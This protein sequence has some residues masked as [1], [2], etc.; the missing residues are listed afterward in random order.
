MWIPFPLGRGIALEVMLQPGLAFSSGNGRFPVDFVVNPHNFHCIDSLVTMDWAQTCARNTYLSYLWRLYTPSENVHILGMADA[1]PA[2]GLRL[3]H[4]SL[5]SLACSAFL[6]KPSNSLGHPP[7]RV[8]ISTGC[9]VFTSIYVT[10]PLTSATIACCLSEKSEVV[11]LLRVG[12]MRSSRYAAISF[13]P[14]LDPVR[15]PRHEHIRYSQHQD[16]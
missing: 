7:P 9:C 10:D 16:T 1:L 15:I 14:A 5:S 11:P 4:F 8:R 2:L 12:S 3:S 13:V 6:V